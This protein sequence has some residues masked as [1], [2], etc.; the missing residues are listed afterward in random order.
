MKLGVKDRR[1]PVEH[2]QNSYRDKG[3]Q[4]EKEE[5]RAD[6]ALSALG[7]CMVAT[8]FG[9]DPRVDHGLS[10]EAGGVVA[11][12]SGRGGIVTAIV[13]HPSM[14]LVCCTPGRAVAVGASGV[15]VGAAAFGVLAI[16]A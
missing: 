2:G 3:Q 11:G 14:A 8:R 9:I 6:P 16:E 7:D 1:V 10:G 15:R 4:R 5:H 13:E 12:A